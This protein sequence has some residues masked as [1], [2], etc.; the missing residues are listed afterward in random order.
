VASR[1][2]A[3]AKP[4]QVFPGDSDIV[5][6]DLPMGFGPML[7]AQNRHMPD[8]LQAVGCDW[9]NNCRMSGMGFGLRIAFSDDNNKLPTIQPN[10]TSKPFLS[11]EHEI[12]TVLCDLTCDVQSV[13]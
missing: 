12:V 9:D 10:I 6:P 2:W 1:T 11:I 7:E 5:Q 13:R 3:A 4:Q 8:H